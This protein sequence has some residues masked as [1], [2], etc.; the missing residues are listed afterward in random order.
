M[1]RKLKFSL[2]FAKLAVLIICF[3][4]PGA[5]QQVA[6]NESPFNASAYRVGERLTYNVNYSQFVSAAH[7]ELFVAAR[8][9]FFGREGVQLRAH[10]ET[11]GVVNVALLSINNDYTSYVFPESGLPYR[12]QRVVRQ[13]GRTSEAS[14]DYNQPA[15]TDALPAQLRLGESAGTLDL[16]SA[17]YR[18]R[19]MP[20][21]AGSSYL[22]TVQNGEDEYQAEIKVSG[23]QLIKTNVGSFNAIATRVNIKKRDDY[24]IRAYFSD[25]EWHVPVLLTARYNGSDIQVELAASELTAPARTSVTRGF[26]QPGNPSPTPTPQPSRTGGPVN[27][28]N[29]QTSAAIFDLPFKIGEQLNYRVFIGAANVQVGTVGLEVKSRGRYFNRDGLVLSASAQTGGPAAIAVKDQITSYVDPATLLP[30]RTEL[31]FSEGKYRDVR[32]YN[33]DQDRGSATSEAPRERIEIPVGTHDLLS[34][35]YAIRTFDLTIQR[36]NSISIMAIHRPRALAVKALRREMLEL[37]GQKISA[38][39]LQLSTDDPQPDRLQV[40]VWV[41]DDA[42]H[43]P[44]RITAVTDLGPLRADLVILPSSA[45]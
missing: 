42:R 26:I 12:S 20:L 15:G 22:I 44:L 34:A 7:V 8:N 41:G 40:R 33:L 35:L 9:A 36:Q 2:A 24:N 10:L 16:L 25:D 3:A 1:Q 19:A 39:M 5:A 29:I 6:A 18:V 31:N 17:V 43:L 28:D 37:N 13:A 32:T 27:P 38:I 23:R 11:N 21:A 30:F 14:V 45:R 4:G